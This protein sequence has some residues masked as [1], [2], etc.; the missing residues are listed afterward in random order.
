ML[1]VRQ[2][3]YTLLLLPMLYACSPADEF[4]GLEAV[5]GD[6]FPTIVT[7]RWEDGGAEASS[8]HVDVLVDDAWSLHTEAQYE[9]GLWEA[10]LIGLAASTDYAYRAT[11][12]TAEGDITSEAHTFSTGSTPPD[13]PE[14]TLDFPD[15]AADRGG[16]L[17]TSLISVPSATIIIDLLGNYVWWF[18]EPDVEASVRRAHLTRDGTGVRVLVNDVE[19]YG[20]VDRYSDLMYVGWDGSG[21]DRISVPDI[22]HDFL[23]LEDGSLATIQRV[24][25][26]VDEEQDISVSG[27]NIIEMGGDGALEIIWSFW[28]TAEFTSEHVTEVMDNASHANAL[29][30]DPQT[31]TYHIGSRNLSTIY[32]VDRASG[33]TIWRLGGEGSD[34]TDP[35][36]GVDL[37]TFQHQFSVV[38]DHIVIFDNGDDFDVGSRVV[39][40]ELDIDQGLAT[41]T[42]EYWPEPATLCY[43]LG[44][45]H[46]FEDGNTLIT[47]STSGIIE[48][49][50]PEG[51]VV[52]RLSL[53]IGAGLSYTTW[54]ESLSP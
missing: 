35:D 29:D 48:E 36:G 6:A 53:P 39:E 12:V 24:K 16:F 13:L 41:Q 38:D 8:G 46:R 45:V 34:F 31:G 42:W 10:V 25:Q 5:R 21:M 11:L 7:V 47:W 43:A 18:V 14:I 44:D 20:D 51:E 1:R 49:V 4:A 22:H 32:A 17:V 19:Y 23:E 52:W 54:V 3:P 30:Y 28:D 9:D 40:Y 15:A 50:D 33:E 2:I 37:M 26:L 27:D